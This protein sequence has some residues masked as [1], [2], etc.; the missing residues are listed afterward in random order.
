MGARWVVARAEVR[1]RWSSLLGLGLLVAV[2]AGAVLAALVGAHR[3]STAIERF[4]DANDSVDLLVQAADDSS[5]TMLLASLE[6]HPD[7]ERVTVGRLVNIYPDDAAAIDLQVDPSG[8]YGRTI[9]R[10]LMLA[11]RLPRADA[12]DEV[13]LNELAARLTGFQVGDTIEARSWSTADLEVIGTGGE[14]VAPGFNGPRL[15][16]RVVGIGRQANELTGE[17]RSVSHAAL[18]SPGLLEAYPD[19]GAW[20]PAAAVTVRRGTDVAALTEYLRD[21]LVRRGLPPEFVP[22]VAPTTAD[23]IYLDASQRAVRQLAMGLVVFALVAAVAGAVALAPA[24]ARQVAA[25]APSVDVLAALGATRAQRAVMVGLPLLVVSAL[26]TLGGAVVA[27]AASPL[28][29]V[30][31]ARRAEVDP[32]LW[33][34]PWILL[35]GGLASV[36]VLSLWVLL[37]AD[38]AARTERA[39]TGSQR[40]P[41]GALSGAVA[42]LGAP[43]AAVAGVRLATDRRSPRGGIPMRSAMLGTTVAVG[44]VLAAGVISLSHSELVNQPAHW[45]FGWS[46]APEPGEEYGTEE[47]A[48]RLAADDRRD[49]AAFTIVGGI[50]VEGRATTTHALDTLRGDL[51]FTVLDGRHPAGVREIAFGE[52]TLD[53]LG[54]GIGDRVSV[55]RPSDGDV[56]ELTVVG[57]V[58]LPPTDEYEL[59]VGAVLTAEGFE[60]YNGG[61]EFISP[62]LRYPDDA[63][64]PALEAALA[65]DYGLTFNAFSGPNPPGDIRNLAEARNVA[66][67]LALFFAGLGT[68]GLLHALVVSY[69]RRQGDFA[70]LRALG[71]ERRQVRAAVSVQSLTLGVAGVVFGIPV[72]IVGGRLVW[73]ALAGAV[74]VRAEPATPWLL[75][76]WVAVAAVVVALAVSWWPGRSAAR[77]RPSEAL[78]AE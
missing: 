61:D 60:A 34:S 39:A 68:I 66:L 74:D 27:V 55:Q 45:G 31:M 36:V 71:F 16:L 1:Q 26:G 47:Q 9:E 57:T 56:D 30:G 73:R 18:A 11:G 21:D 12:P 29:P 24:I 54:V 49:A 2:V 72:G 67:A 19:L 76:L 43:P 37:A 40:R 78:R 13:M 38:S 53:E 52:Q 15:R 35:G 6:A 41:S 63:D 70:I 33:W 59:D 28:L 75:I 77:G 48:R 69:R 25:S 4:R 65:E 8:Q 10:P 62:V 50:I 44:G 14:G 17:V 58:V 5:A 7:V 51:M 3:T 46:S 20:P 42:R 22:H 32:G 23:E 64:V